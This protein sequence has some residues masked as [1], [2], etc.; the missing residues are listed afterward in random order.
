MEKNASI[1]ESKN[2]GQNGFEVLN[3]LYARDAKTAYAIRGKSQM[4]HELPSDR[5]DLD[6][7]EYPVIAG[8][9]G[10]TFEVLNLAPY[11]HHARDR[12]YGY[13]WGER[14]EG[15]DGPTFT[16]LGGNFARDAHA[17]YYRG[18]KVE[19]A[20]MESFRRL[21]DFSTFAVD[22]NH[23]Y[24]GDL[25]GLILIENADPKTF[26]VLDELYAVDRAAVYRE[27]KI[28]RGADLETF[29]VLQDRFTHSM[30]YSGYARD[31]NRV[32]YYGEVMPEAHSPSFVLVASPFS[33]DR[34]TVYFHNQ[35]IPGSDPATFEY[36][37]D[38]R[39]DRGKHW[40][41]KDKGHWY[42]NVV[43]NLETMKTRSTRRR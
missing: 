20:D 21:D 32:Y 5:R 41:A 28:I 38:G 29:E 12:R 31:K 22:K 43:P 10:P 33:K 14:I 19:E 2:A 26:R 42:R 11:A 36:F 8:S 27:D 3:Q 34:R 39:E 40:D 15:S 4:M 6:N 30:H 18:H 1:S 16:D 7:Y 37:R 17:I 25:H 23:T 9:D 13:F 24:H 35:K